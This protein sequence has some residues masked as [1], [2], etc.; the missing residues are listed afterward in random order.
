MEVKS[1]STDTVDTNKTTHEKTKNHEGTVLPI[2]LRAPLQLL[3]P[4]VYLC[5]ANSTAQSLLSN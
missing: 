2:D 5:Y 1:I 3:N 4:K